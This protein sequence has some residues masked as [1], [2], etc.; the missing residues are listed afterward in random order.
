M[1]KTKLE[2]VEFGDNPDEIY[3]FLVD[4]EV[5]PDGLDLS[6]LR[7]S[8][9]RNFDET[10]RNHGCLMMF[11]GDEINE[12]ISRNQVDPDRMHESLVELALQEGVLKKS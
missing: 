11:T 10:L 12:L 6:L 5:S 1:K 8:D 4:L 9:P 7:L 2:K 3:Y